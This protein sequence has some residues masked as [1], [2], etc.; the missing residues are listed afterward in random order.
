LK[1]ADYARTWTK[2]LNEPNPTDTERLAWWRK[3]YGLT[4]K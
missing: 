3:L 4:E 1:R 2:R